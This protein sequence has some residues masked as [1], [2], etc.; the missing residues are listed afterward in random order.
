[1]G[2]IQKLF[3]LI[4]VLAI[5]LGAFAGCQNPDAGKEPTDTN[6]GTGDGD[7]TVGGD[8]DDKTT[9]SGEETTVNPKEADDLIDVK[10][11]EST[12][13][14]VILS[15]AT[16]TYEFESPENVQ[17]SGVEQAI[18]DRNAQVVERCNIEFNIVPQAGTWDDR[19]SFLTTI[20]TNGKLPVSQYDLI[21]THQAYLV[22]ASIEGYGWDFTKLPNIDV[23]KAWWSEVYY[24]E[25]NYNGAIYTMYGDIAYTLYEYL[26]VIFFNEMM[27]DDLAI[28][29]LYDLAID[30]DWTFAKL[31]EYTTKVTTDMDLL[32]EDREYGLLTGAHANRAF[33]SSF[34]CD[35]A[36]KNADGVHEFA[37][38]LD[39][40]IADR[41]Q[42]VAD[43]VVETP[44]V[45]CDLTYTTAADALNPIFSA[46]KSLFYAQMLGQASYFT[47]NMKSDY[48][49]LPYPKYDENQK[50]YRTEVCDEVTAVLAPKNCKNADMTGTVT[51]MTAMIGYFDVVSV[52]YGEKLQY[53]YFNNPKCVKS[54]D[55][56]RQAFAPSFS[57]VYSF[58]L[59]F[60]NSLLSGTISSSAPDGIASSVANAYGN[61]AGVYRKKLRD[62]YLSLDKIAEKS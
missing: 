52:Y 40:V 35:L 9:D 43:F 22:S 56:I 62:I 57:M 29:D 58:P 11:F 37:K 53:Q 36:P 42:A 20:R 28:D 6:E 27:A 16:T 54:L 34:N 15:R 30:G 8:P 13:E 12:Q 14:F 25:C 33:G 38:A 21:A 50:E 18:F 47:T 10:P 3:C 45:L 32:E 26:Q 46:G 51:E 17:L 41:M 2:R 1:M 55:I 49:V 44:Q 60:P 7:A 5:C 39:P 4:L 31:Q 48:G 19:D 24:D 61:N 23:T 59:D